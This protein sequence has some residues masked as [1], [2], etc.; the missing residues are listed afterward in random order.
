VSKQ[1][2]RKKARRKKTKVVR[3]KPRKKKKRKKGKSVRKN[4]EATTSERNTLVEYQKYL[5]KHGVPPS[6]RHLADLLG[7]QH[8]AIQ[9]HLIRLRQKGH[10]EPKPVK[11]TV[12]QLVL[13][14]KG[15]KAL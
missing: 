5:G 3:R 12:T 14:A 15:R 9:V 11:I 4:L 10:L 8:N 7:F 6:L 2:S 13:S 1:P